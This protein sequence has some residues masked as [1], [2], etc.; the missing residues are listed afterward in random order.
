MKLSKAI[1]LNQ[2]HYEWLLPLPDAD[3]TN[4][5]KIGIEAMKRVDQRRNDGWDTSG[6]LLPGET[7]E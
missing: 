7:T 1:E 2:F 5:T 4:A 3:L 6:E